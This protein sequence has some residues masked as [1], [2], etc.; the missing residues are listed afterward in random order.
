MRL[1]ESQNVWSICQSNMGDATRCGGEQSLATPSATHRMHGW[2][3]SWAGRG[4]AHTPVHSRIRHRRAGQLVAH[5]GPAHP[6][7]TRRCS[8]SS[9]VPATTLV[10]PKF[11]PPNPKGSWRAGVNVRYVPPP[12]QG[13]QFRTA[14]QGG[15][16]APNS[17]TRCDVHEAGKINF[18]EQK[19][20]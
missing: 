7:F 3:D 9:G 20:W 8:R 16:H 11:R 1:D 14:G 15:I 10:L 18:P 4:R 19:H 5:R 6:G 13:N 2:G 12:R 17:P